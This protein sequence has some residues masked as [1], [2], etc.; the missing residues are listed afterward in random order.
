MRITGAGLKETIR[1]ISPSPRKPPTIPPI[2]DGATECRLKSANTKAKRRRQQPGAAF[3]RCVTGMKQGAPQPALLS[4]RGEFLKSEAASPA[5]PWMSDGMMIL[6]ALPSA[7][8]A[9]ASKTL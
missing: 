1:T 2:Y 8:F 7:A 5:K 6:V 4:R 3:S 9:K